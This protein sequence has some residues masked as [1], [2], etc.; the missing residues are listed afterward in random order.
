MSNRNK[1]KR[2]SRKR[3]KRIFAIEIIVLV[4]LSVVLFGAIWFTHKMSLI[5]HTELDTSRLYT[6]D[7]VNNNTETASGDVSETTQT[8]DLTGIDVIALVG[9]DTRPDEEDVN[10]SDTMII[11]VINHNKKEIRLCSLYRDTYLNVIN[12]YYGNPDYYTKANAAYN[13]GGA[14][15][16]LSMLNL[17]L[18]LNI[19]EYMT[20]DFKALAEVVDLLG[21]LD[22]DMTKEEVGHV[23]N[24][25]VETSAACGVE[26]EALEYPDDPNFDGAITETFHC[27]G[28]QAVSYARIRYTSGNDFR[29]ASRQREVLTLI[30]QKAQAADIGTID[31]VLN[32]VLPDITTNIDN[33]KLISVITSAVTYGMGTDTQA[34]FPFVHVED[35]GSRTGDDVVLPVTLAYNVQRLHEF[36]FPDE[37]YSPSE[38][39]LSYSQHISDVCGYT[40]DD[41][42][43]ASQ[44]EDGAALDGISYEDYVATV[45]NNSDDTSGDSGT[46]NS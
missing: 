7:Q 13:Y 27:N 29:R 12:D 24:Y 20:V 32:A 35:D 28:T 40:S 46:E 17:N 39:V 22:I 18:D 14:E 43:W 42:E 33:M 34:G 23:N 9:L 8:Q 38:T 5:N 11:C 21:G 3:R 45:N 19:T 36:L 2:Y 37:E 41:I 15:Q 16:F 4:C 30:K 26:Y 44:I 10:N 25:N 6:S 1:R 31:S